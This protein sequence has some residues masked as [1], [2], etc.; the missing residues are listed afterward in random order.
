[1]R[2][3]AGKS[4]GDSSGKY[5]DDQNG[6][7]RLIDHGLRLARVRAPGDIVDHAPT[8]GSWFENPVRRGMFNYLSL[9]F[10]VHRYR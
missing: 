5:V 7:V 2:Q 1:M 10:R 9:T 4:D 6:H 8:R 3:L